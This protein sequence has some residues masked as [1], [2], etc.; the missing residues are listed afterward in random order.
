MINGDLMPD[1]FD[2]VHYVGSSKIQEG[3]VDG[4]AFHLRA[5][6]LRAPRPG[7]SFNSLDYFGGMSRTGQLECIKLLSRVRP[8]QGS[9]YAE[10]N[11]GWALD[12]LSDVLPDTAFARSPL[13][14]DDGYLPDPS[15]CELLGLPSPDTFQAEVVGE[16]LSRC[17][18]GLR[19]AT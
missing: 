18:Q 9:M 14:P 17:V 15:H 11:V 6:D 19:P 13:G 1:N 16:I 4:T 8:G 3:R 5:A 2:V 12:Q 10:I 7:L